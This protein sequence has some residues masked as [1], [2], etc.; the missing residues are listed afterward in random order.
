[1]ARTIGSPSTDSWQ[2][3]SYKASSLILI[4]DTLGSNLWLLDQKQMA[5]W[6]GAPAVH[7]C[8]LV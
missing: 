5:F 4:L 7:I 2:Y 1:M 6:I 3:C 8:A